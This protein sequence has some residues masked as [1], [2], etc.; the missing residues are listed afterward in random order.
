V[1]VEHLSRGRSDL[2][3]AVGAEDQAAARSWAAHGVP[4]PAAAARVE[5]LEETVRI[6]RGRWQSHD[7][8]DHRGP[9]D[10][11]ST[12][13]LETFAAAVRRRREPGS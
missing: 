5:A 9:P 10:F 1:A 3:L 12:G 13:M 11:P 4:Y 7:G 6:V 8:F 2:R